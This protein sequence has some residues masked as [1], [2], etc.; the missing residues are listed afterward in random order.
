MGEALLFSQDINDF[1]ASD[2]KGKKIQVKYTED[3]DA[4]E[5]VTFTNNWGPYKSTSN[6]SYNL[7]LDNEYLIRFSTSYNTGL[8]TYYGYKVNSDGSIIYDGIWSNYFGNIINN[9]YRFSY[10]QEDE[11]GNK[12][13]TSKQLYAH[14]Y[15]IDKTNRKFD[16]V[17]NRLLVDGN[18]AAVQGYN[19]LY[20]LSDDY[21]LYIKAASNSNPVS[22]KNYSFYIVKLDFNNNKSYISSNY[23]SYNIGSYGTNRGNIFYVL[24]NNS[25]IVFR[26]TLTSSSYTSGTI[27][28][29]KI[30]YNFNNS[31]L[32][33]NYTDYTSLQNQCIK[34]L[35]PFDYNNNLVYFLYCPKDASTPSYT[36]SLYTF[37]VQTGITSKIKEYDE[38]LGKHDIYLKTDSNSSLY[39]C[40]SITRSS[41][42]KINKVD[43]SLELINTFDSSL[44]NS[45]SSIVIGEGSQLYHDEWITYTFDYSTIY[46][47]NVITQAVKKANPNNIKGITI[48]SNSTN[49]YNDIVVP[50]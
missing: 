43:Y 28:I 7:Q 44:P 42:Y 1:S 49:T 27:K 5:F 31:V 20:Y 14:L 29:T 50:E 47:L 12:D 48:K 15:K 22:N 23:L 41:I 10:T 45:S 38:L 9:E 32:T 30:D 40:D 35:I 11:N 19:N 16:I 33:A 24:P 25:V 8:D 13:E 2:I 21:Y 18:L 4:G 36:W 46:A 26:E 3:L 37:N 17:G 39:L 34:Q 6:G